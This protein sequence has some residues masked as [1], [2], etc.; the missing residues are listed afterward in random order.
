MEIVKN[1]LKEEYELFVKII[2]FLDKIKQIY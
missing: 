2:S 1:K